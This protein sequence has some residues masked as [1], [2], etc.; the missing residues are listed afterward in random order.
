MLENFELYNDIKHQLVVLEATDEKGDFSCGAAFHIGDGLFVTAQHNVQGKHSLRTQTDEPIEIIQA[1]LPETKEPD[2]AVLRTNFIPPVLTVKSETVGNPSSVREKQSNRF[3]GLGS[4]LA[5]SDLAQLYLLDDV[6]VF[7]FPPIPMTTR[8][9]LVAVRAQVNAFVKIRHRKDEVFILS[10]TARG[11]FSGGPVIDRD[12]NLI[13]VCIEGLLHSETPVEIGFAA[14]LCLDPLLELLESNKL[15]PTN[16]DEQ[17][18][19]WPDRKNF[20]SQIQR[21]SN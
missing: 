19:Q 13:G 15:Y 7:G 6:F 16:N 3:I 14:A 10:S 18:R 20:A 12:K 11:G 17:I 9:E 4:Y 2:V 21:R 5:P 8:A 1:Y